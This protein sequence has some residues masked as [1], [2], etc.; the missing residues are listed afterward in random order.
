M[1]LGKSDVYFQEVEN[2]FIS[3]EGSKVRYVPRALLIDLEPGVL[4]SIRGSHQ[5]GTLFKPDNYIHGTSGAGNNWAKGQY[6]EGAEIIEDIMDQIRKEVEEC[7]C[8]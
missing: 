6:T 7:D 1:L 2:G 8:F 4:D 5:M 3:N